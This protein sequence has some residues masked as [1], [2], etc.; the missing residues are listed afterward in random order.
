M[1]FSNLG[2]LPDVWLQDS[3]SIPISCQHT[4]GWLCQSPS[5]RGRNQ[6][7][8]TQLGKELV[9]DRHKHQRMLDL[10]VISQSEHQTYNTKEKQGR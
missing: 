6:G 1:K 3:V 8:G 10:N 9:S 5:T 7:P 4:S 2:S